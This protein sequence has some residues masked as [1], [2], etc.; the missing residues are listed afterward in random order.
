MALLKK[1]YGAH[2]SENARN[3]L[4][5]C[6]GYGPAFAIMNP[7]TRQ[8]YV[9]LAMEEW[10]ATISQIDFPFTLEDTTI[11]GVNCV[12][13]RTANTSPHAPV[14]LFIHASAFI[15]G[16]AR[17]NA[18]AVLPACHLTGCECVSVDYTL[19]PD[20]VFPTQLEQIERVYLK[21]CEERGAEN[22]VLFGD[23]AGATMAL[24]SLHRW[25]R[26]GI[27]H[28]ASAV[29]VSPLADAD[30]VSDTYVTLR[31]HD[32]IFSVPGAA[33]VK[34]IFELYAPGED[35]TNPEVSPISGDFD[36]MPPLLIHVG[37]REI[38]LGDGARLAEKARR[39]GVDVSLRV[40][41]GLFHLF[42]MHWQIEDTKAAFSDIADF[43]KRTTRG[44]ARPLTRPT[45]VSA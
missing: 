44:A 25:R 5:A 8:I 34:A 11:E 15:A 9:R 20:A 10:S 32:P 22:I 14:F 41:D 26:K 45:A 36:G 4:D 12:H 28:P 23:S 13:Y 7:L 2:L 30:P 40:F 27:Q 24:A 19:A 1:R 16:S 37:S 31:K 38:F 39:A 6:R 33:G 29:L 35:Y 21:L 42:H 3:A 43:V 17:A 18:S